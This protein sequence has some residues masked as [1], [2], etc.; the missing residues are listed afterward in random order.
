MIRILLVAL[1]EVRSYLQDKGDLSF[2]L[3]IPIA[4]FALMYGAFGGQSHFHGTAHIVNEDEGGIYSALLL[5]RLQAQNNIDV[6]L[7]P[8]AEAEIKLERSDLLLALYIPPDFS[9][10]LKEGQPAQLIFKQRGNGG[11]EGQIV[12][13]IIK[14]VCQQIS[15][16]FQVQA[17][18]QDIIKGQNIPPEHIRI[19]VQKFLDRELEHPIIT[20]S[21][22]AIGA[23]PDPVKQFLPGII[24]M[25]V[26]FAIT[27]NARAIIEESKKGTLE[28]LMI[29]RLTTGQLFLGKF[30][31]GVFRGFLQTLI[32]LVLA[33]AVF[34]VFTPLSFL[35]CLVI[36][37]VYAAAASALGLVIAV[38]IR[39]EDAATWV[40]VFFTMLMTMLGGTFFTVASGS[41]WDTISRFS[42]NTYANDAIKTVLI[43]GGALADVSPAI[44]IL[45]GV[46]VIGVVLSRIFFKVVPGGK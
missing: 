23:R 12:A 8:A 42:I 35:S 44:G 5:N 40:A 1:K 18:V 30:I 37:L 43:D 31:G 33:Y 28:R 20:V 32:L 45:A 3:L 29:T 10:R 15:Q 2:S 36:A 26:L 13:G 39:S 4:V 46:A 41:I 6:E 14:G 16:E 24:T 19:T 11:Q 38:A 27:L 21:E 7:L 22:Q 25:F 9:A 34:R 17:Q